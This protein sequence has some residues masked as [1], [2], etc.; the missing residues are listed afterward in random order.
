[1]E[2][3]IDDH[4]SIGEIQTEF[5]EKFPNLKIL[6]FTKKHMPGEISDKADVLSDTILIGQARKKHNKAHLNIYPFQTVQLIEQSFEDKFGLHVQIL[7]KAGKDWL[8]TTSTD[9]WTLAKQNEIGG[10][11]FVD[12]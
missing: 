7:R 1:M 9:G 10:E 11:A 5:H 4:R 2:I 8:I 12:N 6:F 3:I